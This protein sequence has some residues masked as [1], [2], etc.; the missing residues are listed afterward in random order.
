MKT[1]YDRRAPEY[2]DWWLGHGL[3]ADRERPGWDEDRRRLEE[4]VSRLPPLRTLDVACGTGF[5]TRHLLGEVVGLDASERMLREAC[6]ASNDLPSSSSSRR[7]S[8]APSACA[9]S[10]IRAGSEAA[11]C[12]ETCGRSVQ[13]RSP[14]PR[15]G[16][17]STSTIASYFYCHLEEEDRRRFVAEARRVASE[18]VV[19][20]SRLREGAKPERW[21]ERV[22]KDGTRW[23]VFK[24]V[25][26]ANDLADEL[27]GE[28]VF[29]SE[30]FVAV[31]A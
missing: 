27:G 4:F 7:F 26:P 22:L 28:L 3:Y 11:R 30:Y 21:E 2:D 16:A 15:S 31:K 19:V 14:S 10:R 20:A 13:T 24:R 6:Q 5:L 29:E 9:N 25:F 18:L 8:S 23:T 1:Y 17:P 12:V